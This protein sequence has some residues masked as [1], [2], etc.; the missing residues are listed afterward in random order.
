MT[1]PVAQTVSSR[2]RWA[3]E[4]YG[5]QDK[6]P[7]KNDFAATVPEIIAPGIIS[8][9][10]TLILGAKDTVRL[11][12]DSILKSSGVQID[13]QV[14]KGL[15]GIR[16]PRSKND[17]ASE[18]TFTIQGNP[19]TDIFPGAWVVVTSTSVEQSKP[20]TL[21]RFIGQIFDMLP[22]YTVTPSRTLTLQTVFR[23]REW[24]AA[25]T[26]PI[27]IDMLSVLKTFDQ[28]IGSDLAVVQSIT[29]DKINYNNLL[30]LTSQAVNPY[31]MTQLVL[32]LC[33]A[34]NSDDSVNK[35]SGLGL[36]GYPET[37]LT[38]PS[39]P[40]KLLQRL[41]L[42]DTD[43]KNP[44][45]TGF[46]KVLSGIQTDSI[47]NDGTWDGIFGGQSQSL[48]DWADSFEPNPDGRP[49]APGLTSILQTGV[50]AWEMIT[51]F[52]DPA[53]N[54][55]YTDMAYEQADG[56]V[57]AQP[58]LVMR[59]KP[60]L[61]NSVRDQLAKTTPSAKLDAWTSYDDLP[62]IS[63]DARYIAGF[64]IG[65]TF[66][67]SKNVFRVNYFNQ[68]GLLNIP[69][70][71][72]QLAG[73]QYMEAERRRFGGQEFYAETSY[74][75]AGTKPGTEAI[76]LTAWYSTLRLVFTGWHA[77]NYKMGYGT[78]TLKDSNQ[79]I[80][81]GLNVQIAMF[82]RNLVGHVEQANT[83]VQIMENG[84]E[85][86]VTELTLTRIVQ[87][88]GDGMDF[89]DPDDF[90]RLNLPPETSDDIPTL[91]QIPTF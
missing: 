23:V 42:P 69:K 84:T 66:I 35:I 52:T 16:V 53:V 25:L 56:F 22:N 18:C 6:Y 40:P 5:F 89:L 68:S 86:T 85:T 36:A 31:E 14:E 81:V 2:V 79:P 19:P 73:A 62:R 21:I 67:N 30:K 47:E 48:S 71:P 75:G 11:L 26:M 65:N 34:I 32:T 37:A 10:P 51:T 43:S 12:S 83:A 8:G 60:F 9:G 38:M 29:K 54:E 72:A 20:K 64:R 88:D 59:D 76:D 13:S 87:D 33:G 82:G 55:V 50:S 28:G 4:V 45:S 46:V 27:R 80:S 49:T 1:L 63:L 90:A 77:Y 24:S 15:T 3:I 70:I 74:N 57:K 58:I 41:G 61:M 78:I 39:I 91:G 7:S 17:P 44:F